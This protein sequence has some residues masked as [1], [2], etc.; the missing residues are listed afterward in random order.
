MVTSR[1]AKAPPLT[2]VR[3]NRTVRII[4]TLYPPLDLFEALAPPEDW[5]AL[6]ELESLT[7]DRLRDE[8]GEISLVPPEERV[9]GPGATVIMAA[10]THRGASRFSDGTYGVYYAGLDLRTAIYESAH[11]R[12]RFYA[13]SA[14][15]AT[16]FDMRAYFGTVD[17]ALHD[18]RHGYARV[19]D[20]E[21]HEA[22]RNLG[23]KLRDAQSYGIIYRSTRHCTGECIAIF[24]PSIL[25]NKRASHTWQ[26]PI[27]TY[28]W[29]GARVTK[30]FDHERE[31]WTS[32]SAAP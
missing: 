6:V 5:D 21:S 27:F 30:Y 10:F 22:S 32:L 15:P 12:A 3:S 16:N 31:T 1:K 26:G 20:P 18:V 13:D 19:H 9:S 4:P 25:K 2:R 8:A 14:E 11:S 23:R 7:N 24:R 29:D 28:H 17:G